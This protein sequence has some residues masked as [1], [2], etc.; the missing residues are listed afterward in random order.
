LTGN[1]VLGTPPAEM[2]REVKS[3]HEYWSKLI[4]QLGITVD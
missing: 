3:A 4:P 2:L 1:E